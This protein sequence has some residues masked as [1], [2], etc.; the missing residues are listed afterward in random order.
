MSTEALADGLGHAVRE[1]AFAALVA[2]RA[3]A[4]RSTLTTLGIVIGVAAVIAVV[5][6]MQGL[7]GTIVA[8][9]DDLGSDMVTLRA[10]SSTDDQLLGN[11][12]RLDYADFL[13]LKARTRGVADMTAQ[14]RAYSYGAR[15]VH[16]REEVQT[17]LIGT[18]SSYQTW[19][20]CIRRAVASWPRPTTNAGD[21]W[22]C[23]ASAWCASCRSTVIRSASS[24][25]S[26]ATGFG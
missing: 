2:I 5:A 13:M 24:F 12:S 9:L 14:M 1:G 18:D 11:Q 19:S 23:W 10:Y 22:R 3:N 15:V 20:G 4:L 25:A 21:G 17:Q 26:A 16:A 6:L 8:Q 7:S